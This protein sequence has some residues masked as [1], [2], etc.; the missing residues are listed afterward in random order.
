MQPLHVCACQRLTH[1]ENL[2]FSEILQWFTVMKP[3]KTGMT[4]VRPAYE[5]LRSDDCV[6]VKYLLQNVDALHELRALQ[7]QRLQAVLQ[8]RDRSALRILLLPLP[9]AGPVVCSPAQETS[10]ITS[11]LRHEQPLS[12]LDHCDCAL[13]KA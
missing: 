6:G 2:V 3:G 11:C 7:L 1:S 12:C 10:R 5:M 8:G 13:S 9:L 4:T